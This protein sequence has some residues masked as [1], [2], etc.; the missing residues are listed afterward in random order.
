MEEIKKKYFRD[1]RLQVIPK[2]EK[3]KLELFAF[4]SELFE[5][6]K[7]YSEKEINEVIVTYYD[8]YSIIRR[9]LVDYHFLD[10]DSYGK[11]Y[12]KKS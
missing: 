9:Y 8:D 5:E 12:K 4:F 2:K 7:E 11:I 10:R 6:G 3:N 1:G